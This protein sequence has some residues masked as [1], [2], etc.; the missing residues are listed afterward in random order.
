M[1]IFLITMKN[2][3]VQALSANI[4]GNFSVAIAT[5]DTEHNEIE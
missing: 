5:S 3:E 4:I 2:S 1:I